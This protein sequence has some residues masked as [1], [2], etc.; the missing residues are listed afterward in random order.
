M[1]VPLPAL[2]VPGLIV[3]SSRWL[4][5]SAPSPEHIQNTTLHQVI[6]IL[7]GVGYNSIGAAATV[8]HLHFHLVYSEDMINSSKF[9]I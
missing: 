2:D 1:Q 5:H 9:P 8:N 7:L 3:T 6:D 4:R